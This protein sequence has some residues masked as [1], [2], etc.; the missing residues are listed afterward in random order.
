[1]GANFLELLIVVSL[2]ESGRVD[3]RL[4]V[5]YRRLLTI[6]SFKFVMVILVEASVFSKASFN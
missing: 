3:L 6:S 4:S 1:M 5:S 2:E